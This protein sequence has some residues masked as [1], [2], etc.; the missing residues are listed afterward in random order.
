MKKYTVNMVR[1]WL[2]GSV[3]SVWLGME[4]LDYEN[5][6]CLLDEQL[7]RL[8]PQSLYIG[9][10]DTLCGL[11]DIGAV[12]EAGAFVITCKGIAVQRALPQGMTLIQT[13]L[14]LT[15]LYNLIH[16]NVHRYAGR[17]LSP[18]SCAR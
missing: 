14:P 1:H 4:T 16:E 12:T 17:C 5:G 10:P 9:S 8:D 13:D 11:L 6:I 15:A 2:S 18:C 3:K 7:T